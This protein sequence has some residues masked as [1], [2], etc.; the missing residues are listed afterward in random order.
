MAYYTYMGILQIRQEN[1]LNR[2]KRMAKKDDRFTYHKGDT[3][4]YVNGK[5]GKFVNGK[6]VP[7]KSDKKKK[8]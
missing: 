8:K 1:H 4:M 6:F 3:T 2:R 7:T 5:Q